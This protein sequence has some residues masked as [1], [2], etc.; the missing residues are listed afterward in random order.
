MQ[1]YDQWT[2]LITTSYNDFLRAVGA[3]LPSLLAALLLLVVG[4]MLARLL[5][6]II[7]RLGAGLDHLAQRF[8][9]SRWG[10]LLHPRWPVSRVLAS[11][12]FWLVL[13]F[14]VTAAAESLSLPGL[15]HWLSRIIAYLPN[16]FASAVIVLIGYLFGS[17][18][19]DAVGAAGATL[20]LKD[21]ALLG[22]VVYVLVLGVSIIVGIGQLGVDVSLLGTIVAIAAGAA[23]G[24]IA[25]AFGLGAGSS[26]DNVIAAHYLRKVYRVGQRIRID[27]M[28]G[29]IL[30][31]T[32]TAIVLDTRDGRALIP[33][34]NFN[35]VVSV[36][37]D[38]D[39]PPDGA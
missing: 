28:E 3:Y 32:G 38:R 12:A 4:F 14:F 24:G 2:Q 21:A 35:A 34:K 37:V 8:G 39:S 23:F 19:R 22:R 6:S 13:L 16:V 17:F 25:L 15:A 20:R 7:L 1:S 33:A 9:L 18:L 27:D 36:L 11:A 26:V 5:R 10:G 29:E 30:E 31:F